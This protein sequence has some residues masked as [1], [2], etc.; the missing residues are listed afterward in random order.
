MLVLRYS[1]LILFNDIFRYALTTMR[2]VTYESGRTLKE[3]I[4]V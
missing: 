2:F 1:F 3:A 4:M